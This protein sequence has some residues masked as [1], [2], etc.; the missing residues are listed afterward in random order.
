[1]QVVSA[2]TQVDR[3]ALCLAQLLM[4][5]RAEGGWRLHFAFFLFVH[6]CRTV[7]SRCGTPGHTLHEYIYL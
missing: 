5:G 6:V 4:T 3:I 7:T 1:M 2:T